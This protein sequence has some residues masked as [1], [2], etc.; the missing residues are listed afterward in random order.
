MAIARKARDNMSVSTLSTPIVGIATKCSLAAFFLFS[1]LS[2]SSA[3][4]ME[5]ANLEH[6][7]PALRFVSSIADPA[8]IRLSELT[9]RINFPIASTTAPTFQRIKN[10]PPPMLPPTSVATIS[11]GHGRGASMS[12]TDTRNGQCIVLIA[13]DRAGLSDAPRA[14]LDASKQSKF[15]SSNPQ[16]GLRLAE[17]ELLH[18]LGHC[19]LGSAPSAFAH[20]ALSESENKLLGDLLLFNFA[21]NHF[22]EL[23]ADAY[24]TIHYSNTRG[25]GADKDQ[26]ISDLEV[27]RE[28]RAASISGKPRLESARH[29][30]APLF[31]QLLSTLKNSSPPP[32]ETALAEASIYFSMSLHFSSDASKARSFT[33]S[34]SFRIKSM[35]DSNLPHLIELFD[36]HSD[37]VQSKQA[38]ST[39]LLEGLKL[40]GPVERSLA[41]VLPAFCDQL[42]I[43]LSAQPNRA[44][45]TD[46]GN[47]LASFLS[48]H[49]EFQR[50]L[51][52]EGFGPDKQRQAES[53]WTKMSAYASDR[54]LKSGPASNSYWPASTPRLLA[55][56]L[57]ERRANHPAGHG[58]TIPHSNTPP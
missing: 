8:M 56:K 9:G 41:A 55:E 28:W 21:G 38:V 46:I 31:D 1:C 7:T 19:A 48:T 30:T 50:H 52:T 27:L 23:F 45:P 47:S 35:L 40:G 14:I 43:H 42:A 36:K 12:L 24:A 44:A 25:V 15:H 34:P 32:F 29:A 5:F 16:L 51:A 18:E 13:V 49:S 4:S 58:P 53:A 39:F 17:F 37:P 22:R 26:A 33:L 2:A 11:A 3:P 54:A 20:P 57:G 6:S 10:N